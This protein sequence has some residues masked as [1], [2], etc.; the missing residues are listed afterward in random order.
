MIRAYDIEWDTDNYSSKVIGLPDEVV[1]DDP[2]IEEDLEF[3]DTQS[4]T[5]YLSETFGFCTFWYNFQII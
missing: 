2:D 5:E 3:N 1:F 4:L